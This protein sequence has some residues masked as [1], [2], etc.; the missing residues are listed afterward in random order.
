MMMLLLVLL[1]ILL[2]VLLM[3]LLLRAAAAAAAADKTSFERAANNG[4]G[5][6]PKRQTS[7]LCEHREVPREYLRC[8]RQ[9]LG[10][11]AL[12]ELT[13]STPKRRRL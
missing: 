2:L 3:I 13:L 12:G 9:S 6:A 10:R 11:E 4:S 7:S 8:V 1:L 5:R